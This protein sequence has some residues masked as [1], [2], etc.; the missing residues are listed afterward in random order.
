[1]EKLTMLFGFDAHYL[2]YPVVALALAGI[3]KVV[4]HHYLRNWAKK[5][6]GEIDDRIVHYLESLVTP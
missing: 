2:V 1:M 4:L 5:T 3:V 6:K